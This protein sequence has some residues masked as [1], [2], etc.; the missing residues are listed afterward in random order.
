MFHSKIYQNFI[1]LN[2]GEMLY[3]TRTW[4]CE[5]FWGKNMLPT[6]CN[7]QKKNTF[8]SHQV[9]KNSGRMMWA[10]H[11]FQSFQQPFPF[12]QNG[13][14]LGLQMHSA[15]L[16]GH[17]PW[18][19]SNQGNVR[20]KKHTNRKHGTTKK[21]VLKKTPSPTHQKKL[22]DRKISPH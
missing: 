13:T 12:S 5:T 2:P 1:A 3:T 11:A 21:G 8:K 7:Q 10:H 20:A 6:M 16:Q 4:I 14:P 18:T 15:A 19:S 9:L 22:Y 17:Y